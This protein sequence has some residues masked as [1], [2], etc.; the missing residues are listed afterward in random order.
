MSNT[1][2]QDAASIRFIPNKTLRRLNRI[3][4]KHSMDSLQ[5]D[6]PVL[7]DG[8]NAPILL[9][10]PGIEAA[11]WVRCMIPAAPDCLTPVFLDIQGAEFYK[12]PLHTSESATHETELNVPAG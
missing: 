3:A 11:G 5:N 1:N 7:R 12:L 4:A 9:A 6:C 8:W 10:L 2:D